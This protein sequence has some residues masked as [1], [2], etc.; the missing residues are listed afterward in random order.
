M[1][2]VHIK[3]TEAELLFVDF[4]VVF[5]SMLRRNMEQ[6]RLAYHLLKETVS[7]QMILYKNSKAMALSPN[8]DTNFFDIAPRVF[9]RDTVSQLIICHLPL[10]PLIIQV[11]GTVGGIKMNS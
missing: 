6:I 10:R 8:D 9:Q 11:T 1:K 3:T 4:S 7:A 5:D 2:W